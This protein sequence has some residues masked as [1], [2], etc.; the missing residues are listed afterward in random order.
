MRR[1]LHV[2]ILSELLV[3][4][5]QNR[6]LVVNYFAIECFIGESDES[7]LQRILGFLNKALLPM[8]NKNIPGLYAD[9]QDRITAICKVLSTLNV[10]GR[11]SV[12]IKNLKLVLRNAIE[13]TPNKKSGSKKY[14]GPE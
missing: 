5:V 11:S 3:L 8:T 13:M 10:N 14:L 9:T 2:V 1:F 4:T 6:F 7:K 12:N